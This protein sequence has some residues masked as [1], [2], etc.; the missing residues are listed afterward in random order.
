MLLETLEQKPEG[1]TVLKMSFPGND[2]E[3]AYFRCAVLRPVTHFAEN[4]KVYEAEETLEG[5]GARAS[6]AKVTKSVPA[7]S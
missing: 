5:G 4:P 3:P 2:G 6:N 7:V 1:C